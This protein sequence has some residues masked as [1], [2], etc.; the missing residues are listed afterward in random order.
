MKRKP[1]LFVNINIFGFRPLG[2]KY[3]QILDDNETN[4]NDYDSIEQQYV[5]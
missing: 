2:K 3:R 4:I 1:R 5:A